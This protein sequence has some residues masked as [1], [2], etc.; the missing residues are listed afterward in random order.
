MH[1]FT[2]NDNESIPISKDMHGNLQV[3]ISLVTSMHETIFILCS[4]VWGLHEKESSVIVPFFYSLS[5]E[6]DL[7]DT[8][9]KEGGK[10]IQISISWNMHY[11][12]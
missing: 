4:C 9:Q 2:I 3:K 12:Q 7:L 10:D 1:S 8:F 5:A 6:E 11:Y